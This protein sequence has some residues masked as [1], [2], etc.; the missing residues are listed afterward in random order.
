M[1]W[2][3]RFS[4]VMFLFSE[5]FLASVCDLTK[6]RWMTLFSIY[7]NPSWE[8]T[9]YWHHHNVLSI[10]FNASNQVLKSQTKLMSEE[11]HANF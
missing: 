4:T 11:I 7:I 10:I 2:K 9:E 3:F 1:N 8:K 6:V 5:K